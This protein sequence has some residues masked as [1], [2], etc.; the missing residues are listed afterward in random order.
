ML[1]TVNANRFINTVV[2]PLIIVAY[3]VF[4]L[5]DYRHYTQVPAHRDRIQSILKIGNIDGLLFGGSNAVYSLS[6]E[7][8]NYYMGINWY[9]ASVEG[10][11]GN[12]ER[13]KNFIQGLSA[14]IDRTKVRYVVY[15]STAPYRMGAIA[16]SESSENFG[17]RI[18]PKISA[19]GY[20]S[21][22]FFRKSEFPQRNSRNR[23]GDMV[24][25]TQRCPT[26][27]N[28]YVVK[29]ERED[30]D[31][32]VEFLVDYAI[33]FASLFPNAS[34]L[35]VLPSEYYG[36]LS[37]D[38]SIF[39]QTLRTKFYSVLNAKYFKKTAIKIIFQ[40]PYTSTTQV[41]DWGFHANEDGRLWRT[42]NLIEFIR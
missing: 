26:A 10:E 29:H 22:Q 39:E 21:R 14:G 42:Q 18:K 6:A 3:A 35:I 15:S 32:S 36:A 37:F 30:E 11:L 38:D 27:A 7:F 24:F 2:I 12:I 17:I 19:L 8:L 25:E 23:F 41:C 40:P 13:H 20:V 5:I 1:S 9:N 33:F 28:R 4:L 31:I 16:R 34:L